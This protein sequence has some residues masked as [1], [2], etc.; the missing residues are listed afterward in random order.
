[1]DEK[2][3]RKLL[4]KLPE[5][6]T[7]RLLLRKIV[8][9]NAYDMYEYA[10]LSEVTKYLAW[11]PHINFFETKGYIELIQKKYRTGEF[12]DWGLNLKESGKFIGTVGFT[13]ISLADSCAQLGYVLS[14]L[15][16]RQGFMK[17]ALREI[18]R[19]SFEECD[20]NRLEVRIMEGN[21]ASSALASSAG[22]KYEGTLR[23][24][25]QVKDIYANIMY[26][27]L[28]KKEYTK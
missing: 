16:Q 22:F 6:E 12:M 25:M 21:T 15:Y 7:E 2:F 23:E 8:P 20:F 1:M 27:S 3:L 11:A 24:S 17:E 10:S 4:K 9:E 19:F 18:I 28:L 13:T 5:L 26:F 14:P